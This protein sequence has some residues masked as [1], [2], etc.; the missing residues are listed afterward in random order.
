MNAQAPALFRRKARRAEIDMSE[1]APAG[2]LADPLG[3]AANVKKRLNVAPKIE[4]IQDEPS[5]PA[6]NAMFSSRGVVIRDWNN[7]STKEV[8]SIRASFGVS[9]AKFATILAT[10]YEVIFYMET[11]GGR[12]PLRWQ[13]MQNIRALC[14]PSPVHPLAAVLYECPIGPSLHG[15]DT[16]IRI[17]RAFILAKVARHY[18][19]AECEIKGAYRKASI[20]FPRQLGMW[21]CRIT[22]AGSFPEI[23]QTFGGRDHTTAIHAFKKINKLLKAGVIEIPE[24]LRAD[25]GITDQ[26]MAEILAGGR[27]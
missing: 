5:E 13:V 6:W 20:V 23:G 24:S 21:L 14:S 12:T 10:S 16:E 4:A 15:R 25:C 1:V 2:W 11:Q 26:R 19:V 27:K 8:R 3:Y 22:G 18:K 17:R 9:R 7:L